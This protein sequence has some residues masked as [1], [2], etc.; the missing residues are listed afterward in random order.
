VGTNGGGLNRFK[1]GRFIRYGAKEGLTPSP[2]QTFY[3]DREGS[4]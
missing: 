1:D 4:L 3:Q 2:V